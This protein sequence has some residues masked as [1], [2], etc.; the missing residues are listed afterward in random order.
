MHVLIPL[1]VFLLFIFLN[2]NQF[3]DDLCNF[4]NGTF[5]QIKIQHVDGPREESE[6]RNELILTKVGFFLYKNIDSNFFI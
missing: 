3:I 1:H 6:E 2:K 5:L 4:Y